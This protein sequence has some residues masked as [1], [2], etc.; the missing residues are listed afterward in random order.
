MRAVASIAARVVL[1]VSMIVA[2][3]AGVLLLA[4]IDGRSEMTVGQS[5]IEAGRG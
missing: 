2:R 4:A 1:A 3:M 5:Q